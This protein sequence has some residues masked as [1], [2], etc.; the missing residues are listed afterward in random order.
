MGPSVRGPYGVQSL[1]FGDGAYETVTDQ[2]VS[3]KGHTS[4]TPALRNRHSS[5]QF[6]C[7]D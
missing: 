6:P 2:S 1:G 5:D 4:G 3:L 7:R